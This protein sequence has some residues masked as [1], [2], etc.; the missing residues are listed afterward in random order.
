MMRR[1]LEIL[2]TEAKQI[3][4]DALIM[5]HT[6]HP[7]LVD[8]LDMIRLNDINTGTD[9]NRAMTHRAKVASIACPE[10]II[11]TD[12]WPITDKATWKAYMH[13][14]AHLG[15]PSLY[16]ATHIDMTQEPLTAED[17]DM[18]RQVWGQ[19]QDHAA[20]SKAP[21]LTVTGSIHI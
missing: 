18:I 12:N 3:K 13:I 19:S 17:Y 8:V 20:V 2:Y 11:D 6:P 1:Y 5:T 16:Y 10:A 15:V 4:P 7:Y 14:Q 9:V 21:V